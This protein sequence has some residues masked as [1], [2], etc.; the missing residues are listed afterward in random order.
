MIFNLKV[1]LFFIGGGTKDEKKVLFKKGV[2][3]ES[4]RE[5]E[6]GIYGY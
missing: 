2:N 3:P 5:N 6:N 4:W 1:V